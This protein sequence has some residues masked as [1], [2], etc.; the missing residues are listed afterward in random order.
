MV[1]RLAKCWWFDRGFELFLASFESRK[2]KATRNSA[3]CRL[4]GLFPCE[5]LIFELFERL[6]NPVLLFFRLLIFSILASRVI[7]NLCQ[8]INM[9]LLHLQFIL[10]LPSDTETNEAGR[11]RLWSWRRRFGETRLLFGFF[12]L[13]LHGSVFK[14]IAGRF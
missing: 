10:L 8:S 2:V 7:E 4:R 13:W 1:A 11:G 3:C 9:L 12:F 6:F 5:V 14:S